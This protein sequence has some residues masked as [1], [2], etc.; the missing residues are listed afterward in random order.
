MEAN[1]HKSEDSFR[2]ELKEAGLRVTRARLDILSVLSSN[3]K[4]L[5]A[6]AV[7]KALGSENVDQATIYRN[8]NNLFDAGVVTQVDLE[9]GHAHFELSN[10]PHHHHAVCMKCDRVVDISSCGVRQIQD[11]VQA[12]SGFDVIERHKLEFFG[13]CNTCAKRVTA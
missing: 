1:T 10:L 13:V 11:Q 12:Q 3:T 5:S 9:H 8:L 4:P 2:S 6:E 7:W